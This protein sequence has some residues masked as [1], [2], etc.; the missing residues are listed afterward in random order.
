VIEARVRELARY[1]PEVN[2]PLA[3]LALQVEGR[4]LLVKRNGAILEPHGQQRFDFSSPDWP[5]GTEVATIRLRPAQS[6]SSPPSTEQLFA[7]AEDLEDAGDTAAAADLYRTVLVAGGP[8]PQACFRL[9]EC[10]Y[11]LGDLTAARERYSMAI[12]LDESYL[13]ARANLGCVLAEL[14]Q[15]DLAIAAF[16]GALALHADF[17][18]AHYHLARLL[19]SV[20]RSDEAEQHRLRFA[21]LSPAS[22]WMAGSS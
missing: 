10:L 11:R 21:E 15:T 6:A 4:R 7:Q 22:P 2:R 9:A 1:W 17:A 20:G 14:G 16:E 5:D 13:E 18:D 3:E 8:N 12:E 19:T